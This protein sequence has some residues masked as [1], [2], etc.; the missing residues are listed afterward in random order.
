MHRS[1]AHGVN[2]R[3]SLRRRESECS[4]F[5]KQHLNALCFSFQ[6]TWALYWKIWSTAS[7]CFLLPCQLKSVNISVHLTQLGLGGHALTN[8]HTHTHTHIGSMYTHVTAHKHLTLC[9]KV[10]AESCSQEVLSHST[11][12]CANPHIKTWLVQNQNVRSDKSFKGRVLFFIVFLLHS[13]KCF[14][15]FNVHVKSVDRK[16]KSKFASWNALSVVKGAG[17]GVCELTNHS[18]L[19]SQEGGGALK[20]Q[21]LK[22][23]TG[24]QDWT[25]WENR[26]AQKHLNLFYL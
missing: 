23:I 4:Q 7:W 20:R 22:Q 13:F 16:K 11:S 8:T 12:A 26:W 19:G 14:I 10:K 2:T 17:S 21:E 18:R 9:L 6:L 24:L 15:E 25:A 3:L 1:I 5:Q